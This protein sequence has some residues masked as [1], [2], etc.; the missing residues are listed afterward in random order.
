MAGYIGTKAVNLSTTGADINGDANVDGSLTVG[1]AFTSLGIDDNATSTAIT[2]DGS[3]NVGVG[4]A[5]PDSKFHVYGNASVGHGAS[6]PDAATELKIQGRYPYI[7]NAAFRLTFK[8]NSAGG[9]ELGSISAYLDGAVNSG[10]LLFNTASAGTST[11]RMR[12]N[13]SGNVGIGTATPTVIL[14]CYKAAYP[15]LRVRSASYTNTFG[16]DTVGGFG[17][18]GS[19]T[20]N[21]FVF[22]TNSTERMRIDASGGVFINSTALSSTANH[23]AFSFG[24]AYAQIGHETGV[25]STTPFTRFVYNAGL[26]G[27]ITQVG[28]TSIAYNTTSDYR[29]KENITPIVG[30]AD[31]VKA[32]RPATYTFKADGTWHDGFLAHEL[33]ELHPRAVTGSKD[34]MVDEEYEVTPAVE[35]TFDDEGVEL[36]P[37]VDAVMGTRSVPDYQGVDYSKLTPILTAALQEA[38]NK[39][40]ELT[41]RIEALEAV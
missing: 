38:L 3:Q 24:N 22:T 10:A 8:N 36:T 40:D 14:D 1:G 7:N 33:Q 18:I 23:W 30:A 11:E 17:V 32:M 13:K 12:I 15:E 26:I 19:V 9:S 41:A 16:V 28:T 25:A 6:G 35:A 37:A 27:S 20:N 39:I 29:L 21:P 34:G 2:I 5:T 31:I 4:T